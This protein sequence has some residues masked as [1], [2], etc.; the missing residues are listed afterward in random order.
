MM[1]ANAPLDFTGKAVLVTGG[2]SGIGNAIACSFRDAGADVV[3]TGTR[4][5]DAYDTDLDRIDYR[6]V[7]AGSDE[8]LTA[9]AAGI[10]R[11]DVLVNNAGTVVYRRKEFET[12]TFRQVVD[13][14]LTSVLTLSTLLRPKLA[15]GGGSIV[16]M[17]SLTA[18]FGARGNPAYGASKA[19]IVELT[20]SLALAWA[21]DGIRVNAIAPGWI[22]TKMTEVSQQGAVNDAI[23]QRTPLGRWGD[24]E[25]IA[26]VTLFLASPLARYVTGE[27]IVVDGG[28]SA[29][30]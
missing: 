7:D 21:R 28:F 6:Q 29:A 15:V 8:A 30:I 18:F 25:D 9:L 5:R 13:V 26:G 20:K 22:R 14:N 24:P 11:L 3:A 19:A 17:S 1:P 12:A 10:E 27:T 16:N 2:S 4:P 23:L